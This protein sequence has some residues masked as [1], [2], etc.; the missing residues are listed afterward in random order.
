[1]QNVTD[2]YGAPHNFVFDLGGVVVDFDPDVLSGA[3]DESK[4]ASYIKSALYGSVTWHLLDAGVISEATALAMAKREVP[5]CFWSEME[6][7]FACWEQKLPVDDT[8][9]RVIED[10]HAQGF[11]CYVLSNAPLRCWNLVERVPVLRKM[12]G[13]VLS[14][15]EKCVKPDPLIFQILCGRYELEPATCLFIDDR[16]VNCEGAEK[17]GMKAHVHRGT[18]EDFSQWLYDSFGILASER[19]RP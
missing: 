8:M 17:A 9:C 2:V 3:G 13:I 4:G 14:A 1:M 7:G 15:A 19:P 5:E 18:G 6:S 16:A 12:D 11:G 10:L